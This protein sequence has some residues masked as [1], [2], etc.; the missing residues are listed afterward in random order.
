MSYRKQQN[1][2]DHLLYLDCTWRSA[3][4]SLMKEILGQLDAI[5]NASQS[6]IELQE[7]AQILLNTQ[8]NTNNNNNRD[9][10]GTNTSLTSNTNTG[11]NTGQFLLSIHASA[12]S[13][14]QLGKI[15]R[16]HHMPNIWMEILSRIDTVI[17][18]VSVVDSFQKIKQ[19]I[20]YDLILLPTLSSHDVQDIFDL[21]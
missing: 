7:S 11:T 12:Q 15:A 17:P 3:N 8:T 4:W 1:N 10:N 9:I 6:I 18:N 20:K 19:I 14:T 2:R 21:I 16:K 5:C 13:T